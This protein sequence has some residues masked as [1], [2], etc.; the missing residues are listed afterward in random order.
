MT[1]PVSLIL[2]DDHPLTR[3]G[4]AR[5]I[6]HTD[7]LHLSQ[8]CAD[9]AAVRAWLKSGGRADIA[10]LDRGLPDGDGLDL[11]DDFKRA[12]IRVIMF[13]SAD[14]DDDIA[15]AIS[16]G[17]EGY[18]LKT[19]E[20]DQLINAIHSVAQGN[21]MLP[22]HIMQKLARGELLQ[23][24][25]GKLSNREREIVDLVAQGLPNK[26]ISTRLNLSENTVRNH[27]SNIMQKLGMKNRV[28]VATLALKNEK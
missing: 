9:I 25:L 2:I 1:M 18:L 12:N 24:V 13:T 5:L 21:S 16:H 27:L 14:S 17:V 7:S 20:P 22:T 19:T 28:Q 23:D 11:I 10:L 15:V 6:E 3:L 8:Q 26:T 4:T